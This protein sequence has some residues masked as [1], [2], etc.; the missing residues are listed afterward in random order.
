MPIFVLPFPVIDPVAVNIGPLPLRWYALAYIGGFVFGWL[1]LRALVANDTLWR[2]GQ[3]RPS[4]ESL[5]DLLV[6]R[7]LRRHHRRAPWPRADLRS[8]LL[9]RASAGNFSDMEGRHGVS[10]RPCRRDDRHV[11][12]CPPQR[13]AAADRQRHLRGGC[14]DRPF[15]RPPRQFHQ[16][17]DVGPRDRR[18]LGDGLSRRGRRCAPSQ[19][20]L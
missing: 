18:S 7:R 1:G 2:R 4:R 14:A 16:T 15:L 20:A 3:P 13:P 10:R 19:P 8:G 12:L 5:D 6:C 9:F 11:S 17:G